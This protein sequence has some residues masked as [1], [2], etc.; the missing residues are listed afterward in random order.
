MFSVQ[1]WMS[2]R[3]CTSPRFFSVSLIPCITT[4]SS[5]L[6]AGKNGCSTNSPFKGAFYVTINLFRF[7]NWLWLL[8]SAHNL[9]CATR[10]FVVWSNMYNIKAA[11]IHNNQQAFSHEG[12]EQPPTLLVL[13]KSPKIKHKCTIK[14]TCVL[15]LQQK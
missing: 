2:K 4:S 8:F 10:A 6:L 9:T 14:R 12:N 11:S 5:W 1:V 13:A 3:V 7:R 15:R